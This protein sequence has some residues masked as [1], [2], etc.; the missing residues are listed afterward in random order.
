MQSAKSQNKTR[1]QMNCPKLAYL[2]VSLCSFAIFFSTTGTAFSTVSTKDP[3]PNALALAATEL[4]GIENATAEDILLL[5]HNR[6][7]RAMALA[8]TGYARGVGGFPKN[9]DLATAWSWVALRHAAPETA[10]T[11]QLM[12]LKEANFDNKQHGVFLSLCEQA[13]KSV[14]TNFFSENDFFDVE[15]ECVAP[16]K[17][18]HSNLKFENELDVANQLL[19]KGKQELVPVI[20]LIRE[21]AFRPMSPNEGESFKKAVKSMTLEEI[22]FF[23]VT[24]HDPAHE[25]PDW[26]IERWLALL[27]V[28][29]IPFK[30]TG[31]LHAFF[32]EQGWEVANAL[33]NW[34]VAQRVENQQETRRV[35]SLAHYVISSP[36]EKSP[37][38]FVALRTMV[39][40][41]RYGFLGFVASVRLSNIWDLQGALNKD[42]ESMHHKALEYSQV[43]AEVLAR[44]WSELALEHGTMDDATRSVFKHILAREKML[45]P[46]GSS[47]EFEAQ[48][49]FYDTMIREG[50][51]R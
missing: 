36:G 16:E 10:F 28:C 21:K 30:E 18:K 33:H 46:E 22:I 44:V 34:L 17:I 27:D 20:K 39:R 43:G 40:N 48:R 26:S 47:E 11:V 32:G 24:T 9:A 41:Y 49:A 29:N 1:G 37:E 13:K 51:Q 3:A 31:T 35:I 8:A 25:A 4:L 5:A 45:Q 2:L 6:D 38:G 50:S 23:A 7:T 42:V 15:K 12:L 14:L 19:E